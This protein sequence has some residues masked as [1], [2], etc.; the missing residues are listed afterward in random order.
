MENN[1]DKYKFVSSSF[2]LIVL[3]VAVSFSIIWFE[4]FGSD[5][6]RIII[7]QCVS[8][9]CWT[10]IVWQMTIQLSAI[11]RMLFGPLPHSFCFWF[12]VLRRALI[13]KMFLII[14]AVTITRYI[15][16]FWLKNPGAFN[17]EFWMRFI[18][19]WTSVFCLMISFIQAFFPNQKL[20]LYNLCIG[21]HPDS[22]S[23]TSSTNMCIEISTIVL[24]LGLFVKIKVQKWQICH[25]SQNHPQS[26]KMVELAA[27]ET[28]SLINFSQTIVLVMVNVFFVFFIFIGILVQPCFLISRP[29]AFFVPS[30]LLL[31]PSLV[32]LLITGSLLILNPAIVKVIFRELKTNLC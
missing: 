17:D 8:S 26:H 16:I 7:N 14:N 9:I 3:V 2:F 20:P 21:Y 23:A 25:K 6:K 24:Q 32:S 12:Y 15:F 29:D 11:A 22:Q 31:L 10:L 27:I 1:P 4:K 5:K 30:S 13:T 18:N 19:I 28:S